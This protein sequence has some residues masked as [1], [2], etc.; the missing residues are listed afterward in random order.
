M[1]KNHDYELIFELIDGI[2]K[3]I[4]TVM[5]SVNESI[6]SIINNNITSSRAIERVLDQL[7]GYASLGFGKQ[8]FERLNQYYA[9]INKENAAFYEKEF[10]KIEN[11][12]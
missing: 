10:N 1:V 2:R 12:E 4:E 6:E 3:Q 9:L 11:D 8:E 7:L 5:P